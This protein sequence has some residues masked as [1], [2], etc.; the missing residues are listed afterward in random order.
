MKRNSSH[1]VLAFFICSVLV[2]V[3]YLFIR[4]RNE[5]VQVVS[6]T[7]GHGVLSASTP[8]PEPEEI[9]FKG[10]PP[11]GD[12]NDPGLNL[13]KNRVDEGIYLPVPFDSVLQLRW[14]PAI[15]RR[16]R[17]AWSDSDRR[18]VGQFEGIPIMVE[19]FLAGVKEE[20]TESP[21]CHLPGHEFRDFHLWLVKN[22]GDDRSNAIVV[23]VTP[24]VRASHSGW[25][26]ESIRTLVRRHEHLRIGGWLMLDPEHPDQVGKTR[27]TIWEIHPVMTIS[28][29]TGELWQNL[30]AIP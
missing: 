17:R 8:K 3:I 15:E 22:S 5:R 4:S 29:G 10:C 27:G 16:R 7:I 12:G 2:V 6:D 23:E 18:D 13:L 26:L 20:G 9:T 28:V 19:G 11:E 1:R 30:G 25:T 14:P 24:R 21:N